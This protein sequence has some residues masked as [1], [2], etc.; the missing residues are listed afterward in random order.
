[1]IENEAFPKLMAT[2]SSYLS[3][4]ILAQ[5]E[6]HRFFN[7]V[8]FSRG[9]NS[10]KTWMK[11]FNLVIWEKMSCNSLTDTCFK[12]DKNDSGALNSAR[13]GQFQEENNDYS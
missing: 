12:Q 9:K 8:L 10:I 3:L 6:T 7:A 11:E 5:E 2:F 4:K 1:M 13:H